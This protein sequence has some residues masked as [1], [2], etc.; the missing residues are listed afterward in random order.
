M[1]PFDSARVDL[2]YKARST[3]RV[4]PMSFSPTTGGSR[5]GY[6]TLRSMVFW[7]SGSSAHMPS[8]LL[9]CLE[10]GP[11]EVIPDSGYCGGALGEAT[12]APRVT[13]PSP[14]PWLLS[15]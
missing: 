5:Q 8:I 4:H 12:S 10:V 11:A 6:C 2:R 7:A 13:S 15:T 14:W 9:F 1:N 3:P